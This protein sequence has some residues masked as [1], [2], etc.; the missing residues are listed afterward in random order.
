[1]AFTTRTQVLLDSTKRAVIKITGSSDSGAFDQANTTVITANNLVNARV[2]TSPANTRLLYVKQVTY[3][4]KSPGGYVTLYWVGA[5]AATNTVMTNLGSVGKLIDEPFVLTND[6]TGRTGDIGISTTGFA[7]N[8]CYTIIIDVKKD[9][10][11]F[12]PGVANDAVA[13]NR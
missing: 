1:M 9:A 2:T 3:D 13:F 11:G 4:I 5:N 10:A 8:S 6:A 7:N 12:D